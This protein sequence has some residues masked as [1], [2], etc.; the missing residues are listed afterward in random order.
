MCQK[1]L[2]I[3]LMEVSYQKTEIA[4]L[5]ADFELWTEFVNFCNSISKWFNN[6]RNLEKGVSSRNETT[7]SWLRSIRIILLQSSEWAK[8]TLS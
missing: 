6:L 2:F 4:L 3:K 1:G 8:P 7:Q 5:L